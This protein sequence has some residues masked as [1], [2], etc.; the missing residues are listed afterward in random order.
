[1]KSAI[2]AAD[3]K[4]SSVKRRRL[5][6]LFESSS[7]RTVITALDESVLG[8]PEGGLREMRSSV[9][10]IA[11][12]KTNAVLGYS[13]LFERHPELDHVGGILQVTTTPTYGAATQ[14][15]VISTVDIAVRL[16]MDAV[17]VHV[18]VG[19]KY[20][21]EMIQIL[22]RTASECE[23]YGMPLLAIMYPRTEGRDGTA[24]NFYELRDSAPEEYTR[25]VSHAVRV[26][27]E[28]GADI[29]K[30]QYTGS[31]ESFRRV[32]DV[33]YGV[34]VVAAGGPKRSASEALQ[35]AAEVMR[36][37]ASGIASGRNIFQRRAISSFVEAVR[38]I[39]HDNVEADI[40]IKH[41]AASSV[42]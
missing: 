33:S 6:R 34:P 4:H 11:A 1:M 20:E 29:I 27:V 18:N 25:K 8:G 17:A 15:V 10:E 28:L 42:D 2:D 21:R 30:T 31:T 13:G 9:V 32:V 12:G 14:K 7:G 36:S 26:G 39:V 23:R 35:A 22:G 41:Y 37:G 24:D 38:M 16:G 3:I 40:A 5:S 19:S